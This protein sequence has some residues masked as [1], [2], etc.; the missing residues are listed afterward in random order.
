MA[1]QF[2]KALRTIQ[3]GTLPPILDLTKEEKLAMLN[4]KSEKKPHERL[5]QLHALTSEQ[6]LSKED[7]QQMASEALVVPA[8]LMNEALRTMK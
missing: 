2:I 6:E 8:F 1:N 4:E 7:L 3:R 5:A